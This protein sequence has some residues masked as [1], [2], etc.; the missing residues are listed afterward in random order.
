MYMSPNCPFQ[1]KAEKIQSRITNTSRQ[2]K[3]APMRT[4]SVNEFMW[5]KWLTKANIKNGYMGEQQSSV[6][7]LH[8]ILEIKPCK[9]H[10][11]VIQVPHI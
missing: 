1:N 4:V 5:T 3:A 6:I 7:Q 2:K 11:L 10:N 8:N 9:K